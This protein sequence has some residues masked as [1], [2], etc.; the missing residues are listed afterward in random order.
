MLLGR[1]LSFDLVNFLAVWG[2]LFGGLGGG[3]ELLVQINWMFSKEHQGLLQLL[4][5]KLKVWWTPR[6]SCF[7]HMLGLWALAQDFVLKL[8]LQS[9]SQTN[10][11]LILLLSYCLVGPFP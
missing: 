10:L 11:G 1:F 5:L 9:S 8:S 3:G 2:L 7:M 6:L 4:R